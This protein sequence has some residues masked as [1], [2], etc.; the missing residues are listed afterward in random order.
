MLAC[1][2]GS[3]EWAKL[4]VQQKLVAMAEWLAVPFVLEDDHDHDYLT[5]QL[6][7]RGESKAL[8]EAQVLLHLMAYAGSKASE[9]IEKRRAM[10]GLDHRLPR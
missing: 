6:K 4:L 7:T 3:E 1:L 9:W 2:K 10:G 8:R 5:Q